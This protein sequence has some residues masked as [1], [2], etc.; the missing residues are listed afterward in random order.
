MKTSLGAAIVRQ[1]VFGI[2]LVLISLPFLW[3]LHRT[4]GL[5]SPPFSGLLT[6][7]GAVVLAFAGAGAI[8][9]S[10]GASHGNSLLAGVLSLLLGGA[11]SASAAPLYAGLIADALTHDAAGMVWAERDRLTGGAHNALTSRAGETFDAAR[12]GRLRDQIAKLQS[13]AKG[14]TSSGARDSALQKIK[15]T[16]LEL[17]NLGREKGGQ[18][19]KNGVARSSAFALLMWTILGAPLAG[20]FEA[21]RARRF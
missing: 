9:A 11:I 6:L 7:G 2:L 15:A 21:Q 12:Q 13:E 19:F 3:I 1:T 10:V 8:G 16:G 4:F 18:V 14:A 5:G 17:A 20:I